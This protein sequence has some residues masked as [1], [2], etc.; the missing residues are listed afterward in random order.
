MVERPL[1]RINYLGP[2]GTFCEEALQ[3]L[4][5]ASHAVTVSARSV[6]E[7]LDALRNDE[8]D[9][10]LVPWENS[11][12]GQVGVTLDELV[13]GSSL[14]IVAEVVLPVNFVFVVRPGDI[15]EVVRSVAAHPQ[16]AAQC[17]RWL[18]HHVPDAVV[19]EALSN[20]EAPALVASGKHDAA[21]STPLAASRLP[22]TVVA[23]QAADRPGAVTRF[24]LVRRAGPV[25]APTGHDLTTVVVYIRHDE[26][27]AL[28]AVLTELAAR[29]INLSRIESRPTGTALGRYV[30]FLDW[31]GHADD[32]HVAEALHGLSRI[33]AEVKFLGS[34]PQT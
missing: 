31:E 1:R 4:P 21:L 28:L 30:F 14:H 23:R 18:H 11:V 24:V 29:G 16:A 22:L 15:L 9:A 12:G 7:A 26:V 13:S 6:P 10:A 25:C 8:V 3:T 19:V 32:A 33:C 17:R 34:R 5:A 20:A 2:A 27:G